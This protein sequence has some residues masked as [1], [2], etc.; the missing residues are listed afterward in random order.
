MRHQHHSRQLSVLLSLLRLLRDQLLPLL[1]LVLDIRVRSTTTQRKQDT[2][3][4]EE[5]DMEAEEEDRKADSKDL[6]AAVVSG[7]AQMTYLA[8]TVIVRAPAFLL[9][10]KETMLRPHAMMPFMRRAM[11]F[12]P[13]IW[14]APYLRTWASSPD[15]YP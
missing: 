5:R 11:A 3:P 9:A 10:V 13:V 4:I 12:P 7:L 2:N 14:V 1:L 8:D 15:M 6:L